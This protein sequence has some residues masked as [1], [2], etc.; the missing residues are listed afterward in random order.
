M[1]GAFGFVWFLGGISGVG[2]GDGGWRGG[3]VVCLYIRMD[4]G[5]I[6]AVVLGV[7]IVKQAYALDLLSFPFP[8]FR[9]KA[10]EIKG[11]PGS[12]R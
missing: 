7:R 6:S 8:Y 3:W 11:C 10:K 1:D 5:W 12:I 4:A 9:D 2:V